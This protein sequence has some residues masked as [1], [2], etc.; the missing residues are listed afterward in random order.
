MIQGLQEVTNY[1]TSKREM[2]GK[3]KVIKEVNMGLLKDALSQMGQATRVEL[4]KRTGISQPTVNVLMKEMVENREVLCLGNA[5]STGG[6]KAVVYTLNR[7]R[8]HIVSVIVRKDFFEYGV[9]DLKLQMETKGQIPRE[10]KVSYTKQLVCILQDTIH[11]TADVQA[12]SV[13]VPGAVSREGKVF[14]IPQI[15]EWEQFQLQSCLEKECGLQVK[16]MNDINAIAIGYLTSE[17]LSVTVPQENNSTDPVRNLAYLHV[18]GTGLGAGIIIYGK[19]YMGCSSFAGEVG[20]M[21][22]GDTSPEQQLT[23][24]DDGKRAELL[25]KVLV[26]MICVLNPE[27]VV[28]GGEITAPLVKEIQQR[29]L[30]CLP[31]GAAPG[32][33]MISD[34]GEKY[35]LGLGQAGLDLLD[36]KVRLH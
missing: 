30:A 8:Y 36:H 29:C 34:S 28:L 25:S 15:P 13:G 32:F 33:S 20:Y 9:F 27:K 7:K 10:E 23:G 5:D 24:A 12:V 35:F 18:E 14:A 21:K 11:K 2:T 31:E 26:N 6:R 22:L 1:M 17:M 19:L 3:P 16:V 4:S